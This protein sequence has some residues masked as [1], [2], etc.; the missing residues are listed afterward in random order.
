MTITY[1]QRDVTTSDTWDPGLGVVAGHWE[2]STTTAATGTVSASWTGSGVRTFY[3]TTVAGQPNVADWP[4]GVFNIQAD[5]AAIGAD[6]AVIVGQVF[7][8][9][10]AGTSRLE[11][12]GDII[13]TSWTTTGLHAESVT[14]NFAAG[15][16]ADR[17]GLD[18]E[19]QNTNTHKS[20][21]LTFN[22]N[23]VDE[24]ADGP[25]VGAS[26]IFAGF[27]SQGVPAMTP[28]GWKAIGYNIG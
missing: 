22:V 5:V 26:D 16:A 11:A 9:N 2:L 7:R 19:G 10:S 21:T 25:W 23:T 18:L 15:S 28:R 13:A 12:S 24:Y 27:L 17:Y 20:E 4:N 1:Y 3:W 6:I 14:F 8:V